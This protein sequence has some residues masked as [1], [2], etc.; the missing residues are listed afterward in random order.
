M[1]NFKGKQRPDMSEADRLNT[2]GVG[3]QELSGYSENNDRFVATSDNPVRFTTHYM[4][5]YEII[6]S[7]KQYGGTLLI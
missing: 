2:T 1:D 5:R 6:M 3:K 7:A 4:T